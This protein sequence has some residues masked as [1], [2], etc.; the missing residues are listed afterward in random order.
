MTKQKANLEQLN[1]YSQLSF[2]LNILYLHFYIFSCTNQQLLFL[3][4]FY[5]SNVLKHGYQTY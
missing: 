2:S 1:K 4:S 5:V 3:N